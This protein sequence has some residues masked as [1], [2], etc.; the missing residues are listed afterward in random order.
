MILW[1]DDDNSDN[2]DDDRLVVVQ[3]SILKASTVEIFTDMC[4][5]LM[6]S[7][8]KC[9]QLL[10]EYELFVY[11][12]S[13]K[14]HQ[15]LPTSRSVWCIY[16]GYFVAFKIL[17]YIRHHC[18]FCCNQFYS[19]STLLLL[20]GQQGRIA[21]L[22]TFGPNS[23]HKFT[24]GYWPGLGLCQRGYGVFWPLLWGCS[25]QYTYSSICGSFMIKFDNKLQIGIFYHFTKNVDC[26]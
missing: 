11:A 24:V 5:V 23:L 4:S 7:L 3:A 2:N 22:K 10:K 8:W 17:F 9:E 14:E 21:S 6:C 25:G 12:E 18:I 1:C 19:F 13:F 15:Y 20:V 26:W 16:R